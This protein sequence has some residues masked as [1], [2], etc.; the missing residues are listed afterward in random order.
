M[1]KTT[2]AHVFRLV[3]VLIVVLMLPACT[4]KGTIKATTDP[5]TDI[6]SST[7]GKTWFT[8]E[9]LVRDDYRITAFATINFENLKDEMAQGRG[10][11]LT[12]LGSLLGVRKDHQADFAAWT[13][14]NYP[15]LVS[16]DRTTPDEMVAALNRELPR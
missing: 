7:S 1:K 2:I 8:E 13:Q 11:Y 10:E 3:P 5:T 16:S 4:T 12:S 9:G 6:L 15:L 14:A